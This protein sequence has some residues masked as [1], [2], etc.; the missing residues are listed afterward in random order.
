MFK[1]LAVI[2]ST[3][4]YYWK[5]TPE[6]SNVYIVMLFNKINWQIIGLFYLDIVL[7]FPIQ[8]TLNYPCVH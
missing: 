1:I 2:F 4:R 3:H 8:V 7:K 6:Y 5:P